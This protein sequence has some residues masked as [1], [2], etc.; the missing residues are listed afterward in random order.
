[1]KNLIAFCSENIILNVY[2][3]M[4]FRAENIVFL[5]G[6]HKKNNRRILKNFILS[7]GLSKSVTFKTFEE[8]TADGIKKALT[9]TAGNLTDCAVDLTCGDPI[10]WFAA[11]ALKGGNDFYVYTHAL[12]SYKNIFNGE[13]LTQNNIKL[14][15]RDF[16][17]LAGGSVVSHGHFNPKDYDCYSD[18]FIDDMWNIYLKHKQSWNKFVAYLQHFVNQNDTAF[19]GK[20]H[21]ST[22]ETTLYCC[23]GILEDLHKHNVIR[24]L[25]TY[26]GKIRFRFMDS[27]IRRLLCDV[28]VWL[29]LYTYRC[30]RSCGGFDDTDMS[31]VIDWNGIENEYDDVTNEV[32]VI[33][34]KGIVPVFI[35]CKSGSVNTAA[36]NEIHTIS[37]RFGGDFGKAVIITAAQ[38]SE[39]SPR[40]Y[41]RALEMGI[42]VIERE[43]LPLKRLS[44][45]LIDITERN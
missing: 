31:V 23:H 28:G 39:E 13:I 2:A 32:D 14:T 44:S 18:E 6:K 17:R 37:E 33:V 4:F 19:F 5:C 9:E 27:K 16:I 1:M 30:A 45:R 24:N 3:A 34:S 40:T 35:S 36:L 21:I 43:D 12:R 10:V 7:R 42:T 15:I 29:E 22:G 20:E 38:L 25:E 41:R 26:H 8:Y 11:G